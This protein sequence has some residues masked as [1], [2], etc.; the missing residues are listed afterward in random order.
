MS[1]P[2]NV[3]NI[4][5]LLAVLILVSLAFLLGLHKTVTLSVDGDTH[6]ITVDAFTVGDLLHSQGIPLSPLDMLTPA[7]DAWLKNGATVT[8]RRAIPVQVL[9][10]GVISSF[11]SPERTPSS[12]LTEA[13]VH[14]LPG[15]LL[16][17]N[18]QPVDQNQPFP[19]DIQSI[20]LQVIRSVS[21]TL[22][23]DGETHVLASTA[24][25]LGSALWA[26]GYTIFSE[27]QLVPPSETPLSPGLAATLTRSRQVTIQTQDGDI[28]VRIAAHTV[29]EALEAAHLS[30]QGLDY[31]SPAPEDPIPSNGK[32]RLIRVTEQVLVEQT[33]LPFETEYQPSSQTLDL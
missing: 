32:M 5:I 29:G 17:W 10:D 14:T 9:A 1:L 24:P 19:L 3:R 27:D 25:S 13:G 7:Q 33:P 18:G 22:T 28:T 26:A 12:L 8:L 30:P 6:H 2:R 16:L 15:D 21:F 23:V 31:S 11:Y 20:S 4:G